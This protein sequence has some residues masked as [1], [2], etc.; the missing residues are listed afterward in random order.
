MKLI[1]RRPVWNVNMFKY[2]FFRKIYKGQIEISQWM[3]ENRRIL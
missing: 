2:L 3:K 1:I